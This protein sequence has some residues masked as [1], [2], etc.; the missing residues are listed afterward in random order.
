MTLAAALYS[1]SSSLTANDRIDC[2]IVIAFTI[3]AVPTPDFSSSARNRV[4]RL[5]VSSRTP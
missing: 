3:V 4:R 2:T 5:G 1:T